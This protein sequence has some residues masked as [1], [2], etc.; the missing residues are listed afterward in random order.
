MTMKKKLLITIACLSVI[1]CTLVAGT[2]AWLTDNTQPIVNEFTPSNIDVDLVETG[3]F[4]KMVPGKVIDKNA[5]V[6]VKYDIECYVFLKVTEAN[7][8]D[9]Y[10]EYALT[11]D[12]KL[13]DGQ[14]NVYFKKLAAPDAA[15]T[16][17]IGVL[18]AAANGNWGANQV[19]VKTSVNKDQMD[20]LT[21]STKYPTL[22]FTAYACQSEGFADAAAA[23]AEASK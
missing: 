14:T 7:S 8:L 6:V 4:G 3:F 10:I 18:G 1:L 23:W 12:W 16:L 21:D 15:A 17:N 20:A 22:T 13:V 5:T 19:R 9:T 2:I 11:S